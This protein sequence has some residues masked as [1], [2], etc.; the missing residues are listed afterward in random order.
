MNMIFKDKSLQIIGLGYIGLP[1]MIFLSRGFK[2]TIGVDS[3][4]N[5]LN[6]IQ[7]YEVDG[8]EPNLKENLLDAFQENDITL[9]NSVSKAD[10]HMICV[11]TPINKQ[12]KA[13]LSILYEVIE[14]LS[15]YLKKGDLIVIESTSP[16]GTSE[17]IVKKV[18][19][20]R[21]DLFTNKNKPEIN[22]CYSPERVIPGNILD[23]FEKVDR[24]IG[25]FTDE[26]LK[27]GTQL[28]SIF[29]KGN[30][31]KTN[32]RT[33]EFIKLAENTYRD[34]NIAIANE[35]SI[36]ASNEDINIWEAIEIANKHPRVNILRPGTGVGG[37]CIAVDPYFLNALNKNS[38]ANL[39]QA[40]R[41][42]NL[43]KEEFCIKKIEE[44]CIE[45]GIK[46]ILLLGISYKKDSGDLR[47]SPSL[48][49]AASL[50]K[51][52]EVSIFDPIVGKDVITANGFESHE[53]QN[54]NNFSGLIVKLVNHKQFEKLDF[55]ERNY[56]SFID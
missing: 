17:E 27:I 31:H 36:I 4:K 56:L 32:L 24:V 29:S 48:R 12:K 16:V 51:N 13:D 30:I 2:K 35:F 20:K 25:G 38:K 14:E 3:N 53:L 5:R 10:V 9:S 23:E 46:K 39:I 21:P 50:K 15:N 19:K 40:A 42:V 18:A 45:K 52:H 26:C 11:P 41:D 44:A 28:Y 47:E 34:I 37:H 49:I 7:Q 1:T 6:Q 33:A 22:L 8:N 43:Y 54:I 55:N